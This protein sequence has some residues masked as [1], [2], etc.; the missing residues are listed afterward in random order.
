MMMLTN[1]PESHVATMFRSPP[2]TYHLA[3]TERRQL[4]GNRYLPTDRPRL[5]TGFDEFFG[6]MAKRL[7]VPPAHPPL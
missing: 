6:E 4:A 7:L 3:Q 5:P 2:T 1:R